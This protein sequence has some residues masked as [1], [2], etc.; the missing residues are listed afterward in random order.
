MV[1]TLRALLEFIYLARR[2][3]HTAQTLEEMK[4]AL[5]RFQMYRSI[6]VSTGVRP[7]NSVPPRQHSLVH[8]IKAIKAFGA[9]NGLCSSLTESKHIKAIVI[10]TP[11][12]S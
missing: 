5:C 1:C 3:N 6:F 12:R 10:V 11:A 9:P 7:E 4:D 8:Y 2:N